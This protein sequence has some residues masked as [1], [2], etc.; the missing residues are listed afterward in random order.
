MAAVPGVSLAAIH[1]GLD[2]ANESLAAPSVIVW[3]AVGIALA[4]AINLGVV[5]RPSVSTR[6]IAALY[7]WLL[8][9]GAPS[10]WFASFPAGMALAD[11]FDGTTGG[12]HS[13]WGMVLSGV[14]ALAM[15]TLVV[16]GVMRK[17]SAPSRAVPSVH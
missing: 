13:S 6:H 4:V 5:R 2:A 1:A 9:L 8:V 12:D 15:L 16:T 17:P 10:L 3:A 11:A 7:L 14:S